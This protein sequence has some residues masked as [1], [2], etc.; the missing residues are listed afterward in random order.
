[1]TLK[2]QCFDLIE[3]VPEDQLQY[4]VTFLKDIHR[5]YNETLSEAL[6]DAFCITL[7]ERHQNSPY[8]NEP[9]VPIE[10][11]AEKWGIDLNEN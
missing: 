7:A 1:M 5:L 6:D 11:L 10:K 3:R 9:P 8:C 2:Q 4:Y